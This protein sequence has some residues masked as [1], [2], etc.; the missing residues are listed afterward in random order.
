[1]I[2]ANHR[3]IVERA[4]A[5]HHAYACS[6]D[7]RPA[8]GDL[9][10]AE[11]QLLRHKQILHVG[12]KAVDGLAREDGFRCFRAVEF[13]T[14]L[15]VFVRQPRGRAHDQIEEPSA[16]FTAQRLMDAHQRAV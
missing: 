1:M 16:P 10:R 5:I 13:E 6:V 15:C 14:A 11:S 9:N 8:D 4:K 3:Q 7:V 2:P 12:A